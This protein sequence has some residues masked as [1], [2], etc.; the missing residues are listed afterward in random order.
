[1]VSPDSLKASQRKT[2]FSGAEAAETIGFEYE[3]LQETLE[4]AIRRIQKNR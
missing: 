2:M 4:T 3:T 1:M